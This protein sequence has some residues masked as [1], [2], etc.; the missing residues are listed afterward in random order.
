MARQR[1]RTGTNRDPPSSTS[2]DLDW[3]SSAGAARSVAD[4]CHVATLRVSTLALA[5]N[6]RNADNKTSYATNGKDRNRIRQILSGATPCCAASCKQLCRTKL[7][8]TEVA[9]IC[10]LF[11]SL[12]SEEQAL[13]IAII[14]D[15]AHGV[16]GD[17]GDV[18]EVGEVRTQWS[19]GGTIVCFDAWCKLLGSSKKTILEMVHGECDE[20]RS[21]SG[22]ATHISRLSR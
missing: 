11:W 15:E 5:C 13:L 8:E 6:Q 17:V 14:K 20:R 19:L 22:P 18:G 3:L 21:S 4:A 9:L 16:V 1:C 12:P 10:D 2:R 7:R